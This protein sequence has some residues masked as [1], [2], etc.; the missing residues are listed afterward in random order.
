MRYLIPLCAMTLGVGLTP[1]SPARAPAQRLDA[2]VQRFIAQELARDPTLTYSTGLPTNDHSRFAD[3][4]PRA[5]AVFDAQER[6]DLDQLRAIDPTT[7]P[8]S[9]ARAPHSNVRLRRC[10]IWASAP[11]PRTSRRRPDSRMSCLASP[12]CPAPTSI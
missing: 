3:R 10:S 5:L 9:C 2:L 11:S 1:V 8:P 12:I 7:L 6:A 4:R